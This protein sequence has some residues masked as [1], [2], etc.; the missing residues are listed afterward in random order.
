[1]KIQMGPCTWFPEPHEM[2]SDVNEAISLSPTQYVTVVNRSTGELSIRKGPRNYCPQPEERASEVLEALVL[3]DDEFVKV[4]D[5][6]SGKRWVEWGKKLLFLEPTWE[7]E[8]HSPSATG[9]HK[10]VALRGREFVRLSVAPRFRV[11]KNKEPQA[12]SEPSTSGPS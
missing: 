10:S 4:K 2:P 8:G 1:M 5:S 9:V 11:T 7:V 6:A 12:L 3:M